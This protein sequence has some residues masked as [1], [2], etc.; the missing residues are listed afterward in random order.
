MSTTF[1]NHSAL[2]AAVSDVSGISGN[3][4]FE[5]VSLR[6]VGLKTFWTI[7]I[8]QISGADG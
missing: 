7:A 3:D 8:G 4:F 5:I 1:Y 6:V 2:F